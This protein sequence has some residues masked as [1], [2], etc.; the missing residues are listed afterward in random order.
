MCKAVFYRCISTELLTKK[1]NHLAFFRSS[2][3]WS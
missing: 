3:N 2:V 1:S